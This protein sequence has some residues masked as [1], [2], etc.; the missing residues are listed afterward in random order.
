MVKVTKTFLQCGYSLESECSFH[1]TMLFSTHG[2]L[3]N[4]SCL[5][6]Y[7]NPARLFAHS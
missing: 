3:P 4:L 2:N 1:E 5:S 7:D 6:G